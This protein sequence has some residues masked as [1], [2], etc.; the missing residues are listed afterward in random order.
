MEAFIN[1]DL[2]AEVPRSGSAANALVFQVA[3]DLIA[4]SAH[5]SVEIDAP[6]G[7]TRQLRAAYLRVVAIASG[8]QGLYMS[9]GDRLSAVVMKASIAD[10]LKVLGREPLVVGYIAAAN[11][12]SRALCK[13]EGFAEDPFHEM[14]WCKYLGREMEYVWISGSFKLTKPERH[15]RRRAHG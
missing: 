4:V 7:D 14:L 10:A 11:A 1:R 6:P 3:G 5:E 15:G 9:G 8:Y 2:V 12:R 13:R